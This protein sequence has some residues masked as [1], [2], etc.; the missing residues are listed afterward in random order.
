MTSAG[1]GLRGEFDGE[2]GVLESVEGEMGLPSFHVRVL[3]S[4]LIAVAR[5]VSPRLQWKPAGWLIA[6][7]A[8]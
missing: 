3:V 4:R 2:L 1:G 6:I 7:T 8:G 5:G